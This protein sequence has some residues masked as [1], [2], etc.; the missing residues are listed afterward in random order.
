MICEPCHGTGYLSDAGP[1]RPC[2]ECNGSGWAYCCEGLR[3]APREHVASPWCWCE[4]YPDPDALGVYI[5]R[6]R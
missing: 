4:P 1:P 6:Q 2:P 5:H 3:E